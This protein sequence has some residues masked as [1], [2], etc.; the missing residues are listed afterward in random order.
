M[1]IVKLDM[2]MPNNCMECKFSKCGNELCLFDDCND[3]MGD[4]EKL[5]DEVF[6]YYIN[7]RHKNCPLQEVS[8]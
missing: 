7:H 4:T 3:T 2:Q 1:I 8:E 6:E 5:S